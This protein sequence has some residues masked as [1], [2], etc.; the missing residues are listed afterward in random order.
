MLSTFHTDEVFDKRRRTRRAS[1][2]IEIIK[3]PK[4]I[5]DYNIYMGGVDRSDQMVLYYSYSHRLASC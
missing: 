4:I 5:D 2:G 3:K 1:S